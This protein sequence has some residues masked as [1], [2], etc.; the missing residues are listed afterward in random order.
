M[1][2]I[3]ELTF[4]NFGG[5]QN[6][7]LVNSKQRQRSDLR[8]Y[9]PDSYRQIAPFED[10]LFAAP[11]VWLIDHFHKWRPIMNSFANIKISLTNL[12]L[13]LIIQKSFYFATRLVRLI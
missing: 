3:A 8:P 6:S 1:E 2:A 13:K 10:T 9:A 12:I 7:R 5:Y 11:R 4:L